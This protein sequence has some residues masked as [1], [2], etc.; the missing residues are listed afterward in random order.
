MDSNF[1]YAGA[2]NL[3]VAPFCRT[4]LLEM[5]RRAFDHFIGYPTA[6]YAFGDRGG[7]VAPPAADPSQATGRVKRRENQFTAPAY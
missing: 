5:G 7:R 4:W 2:V 1:Q 3:F 6:G